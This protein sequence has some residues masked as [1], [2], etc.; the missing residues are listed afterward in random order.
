MSWISIYIFL[1]FWDNLTLHLVILGNANHINSAA[2]LQ[3]DLHCIPWKWETHFS[4]F[5]FIKRKILLFKPFDK[6]QLRIPGILIREQSRNHPKVLPFPPQ[7]FCLPPRPPSRSA[8]L[9]NVIKRAVIIT[10]AHE[11]CT[12]LH[13]P[14][15]RQ[16]CCPAHFPNMWKSLQAP[17]SLQLRCAG[18][19]QSLSHL[20]G[21]PALSD[22]PETPTK[23]PEW[24][25]R[26]FALLNH[27]PS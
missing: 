8:H 15:R 4:S 24:S 3:C 20:C 19:T 22:H 6:K 25:P 11:G 16:Q 21:A 27:N 23:G 12:A 10:A 14:W 9:H 17:G 13:A 2:R 1:F 5:I 7:L 26:S 18:G